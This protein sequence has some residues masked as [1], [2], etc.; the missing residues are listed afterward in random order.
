MGT[1]ISVWLPRTSCRGYEGRAPAQRGTHKCNTL[2][3]ADRRLEQQ[4]LAP[5]PRR[6][7]RNIARSK[8]GGKPTF[9]P[10]ACADRQ[11]TGAVARERGGTATR[12][13]DPKR[14]CDCD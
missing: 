6:R 8:S 4:F 2:Q 1:P 12:K 10:A 3:S 14:P 7:P 11:L 9:V 5:L 13:P